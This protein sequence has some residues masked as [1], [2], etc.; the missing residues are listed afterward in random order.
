[1]EEMGGFALVLGSERHG[2][3]ISEGIDYDHDSLFKGLLVPTTI[4]IF[5]PGCRGGQWI[6][7]V[8]ERK[9]LAGRFAFQDHARKEETLGEEINTGNVQQARIEINAM[10]AMFTRDF[11]STPEA[12]HSRSQTAHM[13]ILTG[14][15]LIPPAHPDVLS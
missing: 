5:I 15:M 1:M 4:L 9:Q 13:E 6:E 11:S 7:G 10:S 12:P 3:V 2:K 14:S 8:F